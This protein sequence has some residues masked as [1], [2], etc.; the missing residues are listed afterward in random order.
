MQIVA[1]IF[2]CVWGG[3]GGKGEGGS[4]GGS[5]SNTCRHFGAT[6]EGRLLLPDIFLSHLRREGFAPSGSQDMKG[7]THSLHSQSNHKVFFRDQLAAARQ[8]DADQ[9]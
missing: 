8:T 9:G 4:E 2:V 1:I 6:L 5:V 7:G 3:G